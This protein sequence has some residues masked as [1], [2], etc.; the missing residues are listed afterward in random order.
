MSYEYSY[1]I[2]ASTLALIWMLLY[3]WRKDIRHEM[4]FMSALFGISGVLGQFVLRHDWWQPMT[5]TN[6][7]VGFEDF[8]FG[9]CFGGIAAV[10]YEVFF[11][12]RI[13][14]RRA[15]RKVRTYERY[16]LLC[17]FSSSAALFL[18]LY[19]LGLTSFWASSLA[20]LMPAGLML[21]L[22]KDLIIDAIAS[23]IIAVIAQWI[24]FWTVEIVTP[25]WIYH[26]WLYEH[27]SGIIV[28]YAPLE[29]V[30]WAF[31]AGMFI[32]PLYEFWKEEKLVMLK[33][34]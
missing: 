34:R 10:A 14:I 9:A 29:D 6:T 7:P 12:R 26:F 32:G 3:W 11:K 27:L 25:G 23:G 8:L 31:C 4:A 28:L 20:L 18:G 16:M 19:F 13:R 15:N 33:R 21:L 24:A 17:I 1:L 5:V 30:I 22:R 2:G